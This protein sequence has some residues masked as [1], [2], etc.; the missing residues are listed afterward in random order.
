[1]QALSTT[2]GAS[3]IAVVA[4]LGERRSTAA[5]PAIVVALSLV[6]ARRWLALLLTLPVAVVTSLQIGDVIGLVRAQEE[7]VWRLH[8]APALYVADTLPADATLAVEGAGAIRWFT[9]RSM[10]VVDIIG[11]NDGELAHARDDTERACMLVRRRPD[12][13]V[14]PEHIAANLGRVFEF[15]LRQRFED[16]DYAQ[17]EISHPMR[18]FVMDAKPRDEWVQRCGHAAQP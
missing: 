2:K 1:V 10:W 5:V 17:V 14:L 4:A 13:F 12:H 18:V 11:L 6:G 7:D 15:E 9:P 16:A 8:R 3:R